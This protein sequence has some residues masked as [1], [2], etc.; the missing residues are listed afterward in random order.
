MNGVVKR[1]LKEWGPYKH[2]AGFVL[3]S[4]V[5]APVAAQRGNS[6]R[7]PESFIN[8]QRVVEQRVR[9]EFKAELGDSQRALF[10]WGGWYSHYVFVFNDGVDTTRTLRRHDLRLWS[11]FVIDEGAHELYARARTSLLDFNSGDSYGND[12]DDIEG[13]NLERGYYRFDL[14]KALRVYQGRAIDFDASLLVGR[15]LVYVGTG[16]ALAT[17][18]DHV[19]VKIAHGAFEVTSLAGQTVGSTQDFDLYRTAKR[20]HR[21]VFGA[22]VKYLGSQ[23]HEPFVYALWQRDRN[24]EAARRFFRRLDYDSL[25]I[26]LGSTGELAKGLRYTAEVVYES[27]RSFSE[28]LFQKGSEIRAWAGVFE[29]EYLFPGP[30]KARASVEYLFGSGDSDRF[31]SPTSTVPGTHGDFVDTSFASL[32]YRNTGLSFAPR[33]SNLHMCR[34][35]ASLF[36]W[37][38]HPRLR[39]LELGTSWYMYYKHHRAGAVSDPTAMV[40]SGY[41]GWEMDYFANWQVA[42]DLAWTLRCGVFFPGDAFD[43]CSSR[44]FFLLGFTWSF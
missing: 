25:Y 1:H 6:D 10:D 20:M 29:L 35:G 38:E 16:L 32:G 24:K 43:D 39:R 22:Q 36:P 42:A 33:Y 30:N 13:P 5:C 2:C 23:R 28:R 31:A 3:L 7:D 27:G 11:R 37:P 26:G 8:Q 9:Q 18:L 15:D 17:P 44:M 12:D 4:L 14:A 41:L 21:D 34:A 40:R 19:S